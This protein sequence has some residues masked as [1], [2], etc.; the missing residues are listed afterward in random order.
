MPFR[1]KLDYSDNRQIKQR[2]RTN[3]TLSGG[4][5]F[6]V[7]FSALTTGPDLSNQTTTETVT[8][9]LSTFSGNS[10][11]TVFTWYD[12]RMELGASELSAITPSNSG[13]T[14]NVGPTYTANTTTAIDGNSVTLT[15]TGVSFDLQ[16]TNMMNSGGSYTGTVEH[17]SVSFFSATTLDFTG[18][19]IWIDNKEII[20][21]KKLIVTETP[22]IG[23][24]LTCIDSEG[25]VKFQP[26]SGGTFTG[27]TSA[28]CIND[29]YI[30]NLY[31]CSPITIHDNLQNS[32]STSTGLLSTAF[33]VNTSATTN[34]SHSEG[35]FTISSGNGSHSEGLNTSATTT[36]SHAE[37]QF[38]ISSGNG[39]SHA[40]GN[41][42][43][44]SG[45]YSH[46]EGGSTTASGNGSHAEGQNTVASGT[47]T[48]AEGDRSVASVDAAHAE[49]KLTTAS[50]AAS[51]AEGRDTIA[52][53]EDSHAQGNATIASG[54][55]SHAGGNS[56]VSSGQTS[57]VHFIATGA[58][59]GAY[60]NQSAILGGI[61]NNINSGAHSSAI[62]GGMDNVVDTNIERTIVLGGQSITA[63]T[64]DTVYV[65]DLVIDGLINVADLQTNGE[66][67]VIDGASDRKLKKNINN[68]NNALNTILNLNP[69]SFEWKKQIKLREGTVFGLIAQDVRKV[70]PAIVRKRAKGNGTLTIEYKELIPWIIAAIKELSNNSIALTKNKELILETQTIAAEDNNIELNFNGTKETALNGGLSIIKGINTNTN[71]EFIINS[72]GNW[73]TN[74]H[75]IPKGLIIPTFTPTSTSDKS[76]NLG[77][78]TRDDNYIYIKGNNGWGRSPLET[79]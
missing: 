6:G 41:N 59:Y 68:I 31:G 2:V 35:I 37:G 16:V 38:T 40:E 70:I 11:T 74:N 36:G 79:F 10:A 73:I 61:N 33:G 75:I 53:G 57:F 43:I 17:N 67:L 23:Y 55:Y 12:N 34:G 71:S 19:T 13:I 21:T 69:V 78:I 46:A 42:T 24:V 48:H 49:G 3:T 52:S 62:L 26:I 9:V 39:G 29:L 30:T 32:G 56:V 27:N 72:D 54:T 66:G 65:P 47:N 51:H 28:T 58:T 50:G 44:A 18:R 14:Q 8:S 5:V 7:S 45:D 76:G 77:E 20:R 1:T 64:N 22:Q 63:V 4:T 25:K 15:Y 60:G